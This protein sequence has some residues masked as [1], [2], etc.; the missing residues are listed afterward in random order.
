MDYSLLVGVR[1]VALPAE[2]LEAT[3]EK[4]GNADSKDEDV[5]QESTPRTVMEDIIQFQHNSPL[6]SLANWRTPFLW[7][8]VA[9]T[10]D[11]DDAVETKHN[12][13][14]PIATRTTSGRIATILAK[15]DKEE[16][17]EPSLKQQHLLK[18]LALGVIDLLQSWDAAKRMARLVKFAESDKATV[19]PAK[20]GKRFL[21]QFQQR[22]QPIP[23]CVPKCHNA[24]IKECVEVIKTSTRLDIEM[25]GLKV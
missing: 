14:A 15:D 2:E 19:P 6:K 1:T 4:S 10:N 13:K 22:C 11:R 20:Y 12:G 23:T 5:N 18:I 9:E 8:V 3:G 7:M 16:G 25:H 17:A 21:K 24:S